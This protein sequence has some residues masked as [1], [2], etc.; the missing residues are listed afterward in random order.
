MWTSV[1]SVERGG[2]GGT[3]ATDATTNLGAIP[4]TQRGAANGVATLDGSSLVPVAQL[5]AATSTT[6]GAVKTSGRR[7]FV[8]VSPGAGTAFLLG[9][10]VAYFVYVGRMEETVTPQYVR[11]LVSLG[12]GGAQTAEVGLFSTPLA[13]NHGGQTLTKIEATG[14]V[15][16]LTGTGQKA[17]TSAFSTSVAAGTH[18]WAA[19]RTN[20]AGA[21]PTLLATGPDLGCFI[22][23][24][25]TTAGALTASSTFTGVTVGNAAAP[26]PSLF[27][28][29]D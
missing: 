23:M 7:V 27:V 28:T 29:L 26:C 21:E 6:Q 10:D 13:P 9:A 20:M 8:P 3:T 15:D 4:L 11:G 24:R 16:D 12:G 19:I 22:V 2:T 25:T 17:N 14:T 18:L 1:L 5:P